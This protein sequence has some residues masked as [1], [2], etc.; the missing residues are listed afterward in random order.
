MR[1][2]NDMSMLR[3]G[4]PILFFGLILGL[5]GCESV[6]RFHDGVDLCF[7]RPPKDRSIGECIGDLLPLPIRLQGSVGL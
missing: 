3:Y 2:E 1:A 6:E 7:D 4:R 5:A